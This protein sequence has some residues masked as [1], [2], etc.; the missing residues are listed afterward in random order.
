LAGKLLGYLEVKMKKKI[1]IML[2]TVLASLFLFSGLTFGEYYTR[3]YG[4]DDYAYE[5]YEY[6][7]DNTEYQLDRYAGPVYY[8]H[9]PGADVY[10]VLVGDITFVVPAYTFR[11]YLHRHNFVLVPR[12]RF[13]SLSCRGLDYYDSYLRF[14]FYFDFYNRYKWNQGLHHQL[15]RDFRSYYNSRKQHTWYQKDRQRI[16]QQSGVKSRNYGHSYPVQE[17]QRIDGYKKYNHYNNSRN[18]NYNYSDSS[19]NK[20][21]NNRNHN[22]SN[23]SPKTQYKNRN[24]S[25]SNSLQKKSNK[26]SGNYKSRV[27]NRKNQEQN[28][29]NSNRDKIKRKNEKH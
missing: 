4:Y 27:K 17:R 24:Y 6:R 7:F 16:M 23:S 20:Q 21:Y 8:F 26:V 3:D 5:D 10:F 15:R 19:S 25:S 22:Y 12:T 1:T 11:A 14:N 28:S 18:R 13:I 9:H 29:R 2:T